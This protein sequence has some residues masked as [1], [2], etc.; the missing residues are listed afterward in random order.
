MKYTIFADT[1]LSDSVDENTMKWLKYVIERSECIILD[2]DF[3]DQHV[4]TLDE[5]IE[6]E[7][8]SL[9]PLLLEKETIYLIGNHDKSAIDSD[10]WR[11]FAKNCQQ[12]F[13]FRSGKFSFIVE[14]GHLHSKSFDARHPGLTKRFSRLFESIDSLEEGDGLRALLYQSYM[15]KEKLDRQDELQE[16]SRSHLRTNT[17]RIFAHTHLRSFDP[18]CQ[19]LNPGRFG[20]GFARWMEIEDGDITFFEEIIKKTPPNR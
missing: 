17:W 16:Y 3:W 18:V 12:Q 1:H 15:A 8:S 13:S 9:F 5:F 2:G 10:K 14:H 20:K 11:I 6:S 7:W 19:Y 4:G